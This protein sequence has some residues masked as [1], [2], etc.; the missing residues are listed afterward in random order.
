M[1]WYRKVLISIVAVV[2]LCLLGISCYGLGDDLIGWLPLWLTKALLG[3]ISIAIGT[4]VACIFAAGI[5][6]IK[7]ICSGED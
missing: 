1:K 2:A 6:K 5:I 7:E 4:V 3:L